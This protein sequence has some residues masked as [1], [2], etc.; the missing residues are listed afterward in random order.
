MSCLSF[1]MSDRYYMVE[2]LEYSSDRVVY[3]VFAVILGQ[4][5]YQS[6]K[7]SRL[8]QRSKLCWDSLRSWA[9]SNFQEVANSLVPGKVYILTELCLV[10]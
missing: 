8:F 9:E 6:W 7:T 4:G 1:V 3:E 10:H 5:T 2:F